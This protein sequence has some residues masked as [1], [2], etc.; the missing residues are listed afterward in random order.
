MHDVGTRGPLDHA[1]HFDT[2]G[3]AELYRTA[4][5]LHDGR[6]ADVRA[7]FTADNEQDRH[8]ATLHLTER[9]L[10]DLVAF[11]ESL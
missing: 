8:G 4:P 3:L 10:E 9:E 6:S 5:Y 1:Y 7:V 2:P 11:L